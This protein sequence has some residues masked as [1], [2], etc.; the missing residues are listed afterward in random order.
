MVNKV[1]GKF[2]KIDL[3]VLFMSLS[4][5]VSL[6]SGC[7][8]SKASSN[9]TSSMPQAASGTSQN[10]AMESTNGGI[11]STPDAS[12]STADATGTESKSNTAIAPAAKSS[13]ADQRKIVQSEI[14]QMETI[15]FDK[16][17]NTIKAKVKTLNGYV[18]S[19]N[20]SGVSVE[21]NG[22]L[23]NRN[24]KL[25]LRLP[26]D[27]FEQF[28]SDV[29]NLGTVTN[30]T[31]AGEDV[32][33]QYYDTEAHI[34]SL[35]IEE[36]RLLEILKKT[37]TLKDIIELE[38]QLADTRY[39]IESLTTNLKKLDNLVDYST[40][41]I[42]IQEV[43]VI[44]TIKAQ[45]ISLWGKVQEGF[46]GSVK[47]LVNICKGTVIVI[48]A[49]LPFIVIIGLIVIIYL[50]IRRK[51]KKENKE[52]ETKPLALKDKISLE[53]DEINLEEDDD[54]KKE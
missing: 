7:S 52:V 41:T 26:K 10:K 1:R 33:S 18:E 34:N 44:K 9:S 35:K 46:G 13:A 6:L 32:T 38:K 37:G 25:I 16:A 3:I 29:G 27:S 28:R 11:A 50:M 54:D 51:F 20:V 31:Q 17:V 22:V 39:Q 14:I 48:A 30:D 8:S 19:S 47:L 42:G 43:K 15:N 40:M 23:E 12:A 2:K 45:Q 4:L 21:K 36:E 49:L 5:I 53:E 24:A